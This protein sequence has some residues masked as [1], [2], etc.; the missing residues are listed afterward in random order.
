MQVERE[1][2]SVQQDYLEA[3]LI[4]SRDHADGAALSDLAAAL[5][6]RPPTALQAVRQLQERGMIVRERRG[7]ITLTEAGRACAEQVAGKHETLRA[8]FTD[9]LNV[10]RETAERDACR[11]EHAISPETV[12]R[13]RDFLEHI[14][15]DAIEHDGTV[16]LTML[17]RGASGVVRRVTGAAAKLHRLAA[18]GVRAG[19][20]VRVLQNSRSGP[21]MIHAG[22]SRLALGR[23]IATCLHVL[24]NPAS[25]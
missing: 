8:F 1:L 9:V 18:M 10:A 11:T 15:E 13:L 23:S 2:T 22:R 7:K 19:V 12:T 21:V 5:D 25:L 24:P 6:V 4:L 20:A 17:A 16:P 14:E 3:L